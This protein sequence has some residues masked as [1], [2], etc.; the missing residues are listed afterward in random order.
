[1]KKTSSKPATDSDLPVLLY[2]A[3]ES[4]IGTLHLYAREDRLV[5]I[6]FRAPSKLERASISASTK[7]PVLRRTIT[8][9]K[10]YFAGRRTDFDLPLAM[11]GTPFQ[12]RVWRELRRIPFGKT[13]SYG[14]QAKRVGAGK[15]YRAVGTANGRNPLPIVVPCH[16]V[17]AGNG[18]LGGY[19]GGLPVK[20]KLLNLEASV[21]GSF[22]GS[23]I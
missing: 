3:Y 18:G 10:E 22:S 20:T 12:M 16:R 4:P 9:L 7:S 6:D 19:G 14:E 8:Q 2:S 1:M 13:I 23:A 17:I 21:K 15:A 11:E 5:R